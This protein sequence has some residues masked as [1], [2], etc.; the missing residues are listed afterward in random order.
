VEEPGEDSVARPTP[1]WADRW[2]GPLAV[3][4]AAIACAAVAIAAA[5]APLRAGRGDTTRVHLTP[6]LAAVP[7]VALIVLGLVGLASFRH[8]GRVQGGAVRPRWMTLIALLIAVLGGLVLMRPE[9]GEETRDITDLGVAPA[10]PT[11]GSRQT[12]WPVW[13]GV[14]AGAALAVIAAA[15]STRRR[16]G[17]PQAAPLAPAE[18]ARQVLAQSAEELSM[19]AEP[20][21]AVIAAYAR[22]LDGLRDAGAGRRPSEA[23]FEHVSRVLADLGV[24]AAPLQELTAL[25]AEARFSTH[26]ITEGH[27]SAAL[28]ALAE[29]SA[30]LAEVPVCA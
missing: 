21:Q 17:R 28:A 1:G 30:D 24:R 14:A 6:W 7:I 9:R 12:A 15:A 18:A 27:R 23:P 5:G 26:D 20:R 3:A 13:L 10:Q 2:S 11:P 19:T 16:G 25:F 29:A 8:A 22:L 4:G